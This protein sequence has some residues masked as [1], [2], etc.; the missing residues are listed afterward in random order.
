MVSPQLVLLIILTMQS[1]KVYQG[2]ISQSNVFLPQQGLQ[3]GWPNQP[4]MTGY[5]TTGNVNHTL[6]CLQRPCGD[7]AITAM[8]KVNYMYKQLAYM[9]QSFDLSEGA[10]GA[11]LHHMQP[12]LLSVDQKYKI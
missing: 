4:L 2:R 10:L 12:L 8:F 1:Y 5:V 9:S 7:L 6:N 3:D 11:P